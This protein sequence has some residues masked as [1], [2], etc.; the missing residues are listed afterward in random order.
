MVKSKKQKDPNRPKRPLTA[1]M[2][3]SGKRRSEIRVAQPTMSM[4]EISKVIGDEW[5][6]LSDSAKR[7]FHEKAGVA[8]EAYRIEKEK[9]DQSKPKRPRTA[10]ASFMKDNRS[11]VAAKHKDT[12]PR[13]LM[14]FIAEEWKAISDT[15]KGKYAKQALEDRERWLRDKSRP[16]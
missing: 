7:P 13:E 8:H 11:K 3:Y 4:I 16:V 9:Y 14:K 12:P 5:R 1:F 6:N 10:Y 15:E 2:C